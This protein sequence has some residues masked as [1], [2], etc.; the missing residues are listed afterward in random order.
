MAT[1]GSHNGNSPFHK[2]MAK[3]LDLA[4]A[5][6]NVIVLDRLDDAT[7]HG[8][9]IASRHAAVSVQTFIDYDEIAGLL[10]EFLVIERKPP[11]D[12]HQCVFLA[13]HRA[14]VAVGA[15]FSEDCSH[16]FSSIAAL[17]L[18]DEVSVFDCSC[19]IK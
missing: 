15:K 6:A 9:H 19:C 1:D 8:F 5:R 7:R 14:T 3:V 4:D 16:F 17:T 12:V 18:L 13:A 11:A 2:F 10:I